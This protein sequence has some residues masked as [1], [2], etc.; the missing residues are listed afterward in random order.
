MVGLADIVLIAL[1][2][3]TAISTVVQVGFLIYLFKS[4]DKDRSQKHNR[5]SFRKKRIR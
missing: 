1:L 2:T 5:R 4:N 3:F